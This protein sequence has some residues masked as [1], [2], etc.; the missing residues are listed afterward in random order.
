MKLVL[1]EDDKS[2]RIWIKEALVSWFSKRVE[3][4][5]EEIDCEIDFIDKLQDFK[6]NPRDFFILD[7]MVKWSSPRPT[8][9][10]PPADINNNGPYRAGVRC[11]QRLEQL[12]IR[13]PKML[14]TLLDKT[15]L[16][17]DIEALTGR[18]VKIHHLRKDHYREKLPEFIEELMKRTGVS[19]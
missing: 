10:P 9:I 2:Q 16:Q 14:Y 19:I 4:T 7:V 12:G 18:G 5:I 3:L 11:I 17:D 8:M 15:S 13:T 6:E 1:L